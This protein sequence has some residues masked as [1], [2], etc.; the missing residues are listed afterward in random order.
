[1]LQLKIKTYSQ[2]FYGKSEDGGVTAAFP[3]PNALAYM[4][5]ADVSA[6]LQT[7]G[8]RQ[9]SGEI[10]RTGPDGFL[11]FLRLVDLWWESEDPALKVEPACI[12][13]GWCRRR[14]SDPARATTPPR[15]L[16]PRPLPSPSPPSSFPRLTP[17][18]R[19]RRSRRKARGESAS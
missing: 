3:G 18:A 10:S 11:G 8:P 7:V 16:P 2:V 15:P 13:L 12:A 14:P 17:R 19:R 4:T 9:R 5:H 1:M 6:Q